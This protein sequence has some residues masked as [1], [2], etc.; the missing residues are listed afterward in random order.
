M[1]TGI[2]AAQGKVRR[3]IKRDRDAALEIDTDLDLGD[4]TLG[5]SIAISGICLSVTAFTDSGF[6]ADVSAETLSR[7]TLATSRAGAVVNLEKALRLGD[8]FGGHIVLGHVD[9]VGRI[10][11]KESRSQSLV[12]G[13]EVDASLARYI[14][15][16]GSIAVDG[17]S[18]TVNRCE[19]ER[20]YV[21]IIPLTAAG[22][23][24]SGKKISDT[25]NIETDILAKHVEKLL[26]AGL[27]ET[28]PAAAPAAGGIDE[29]FLARYG[30]L[31]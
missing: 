16:K 10:V 3:I 23:T 29:D 21:N 30:F 26:S 28:A 25:V 6:S 24:L 13:F 18:L 11:E 7:T 4:V 9:G 8:R 2:V 31:K 19:R 20:F 22:T 15:P 1:F 27:E 17:I 14:V 12:F 5:D